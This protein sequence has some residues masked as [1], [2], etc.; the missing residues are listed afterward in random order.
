MH[1]F[2]YQRGVVSSLETVLFRP[3]IREQKA[4]FHFLD[5]I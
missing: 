3:K 1:S 2:L 4:L 5:P